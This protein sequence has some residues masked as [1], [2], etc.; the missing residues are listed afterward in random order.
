MKTLPPIPPNCERFRKRDDGFTEFQ[1]VAPNH[2][3]FGTRQGEKP[4]T[5]VFHVVIDD[6]KWPPL[7]EVIQD[8]SS[9][10]EVSWRKEADRIHREE[11][12]P[13][14]TSPMGSPE[15]LDAIAAEGEALNTAAAWRSWAEPEPE[16]EEAP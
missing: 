10:A 5:F 12:V 13:K 1:I 8:A 9:V 4:A 11:V 6:P 14:R 3:D 15:Y 2:G 16:S 7:P